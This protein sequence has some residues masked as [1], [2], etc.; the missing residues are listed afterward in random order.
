MIESKEESHNKWFHHNIHRIHFNLMHSAPPLWKM[1]MW[2]TNKSNNVRLET[3]RSNQ[4]LRPMELPNKKLTIS[5]STHSQRMLTK[6]APVPY[7]DSTDIVVRSKIHLPPLRTASFRTWPLIQIIPSINC[8]ESRI[9]W[10]SLFR[11]LRCC[12]IKCYVCQLS[13]TYSCQ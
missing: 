11:A 1:Y 9:I 6:C 8:F 7:S 10:P 2:T 4:N 3:T 5:I 13:V 12:F